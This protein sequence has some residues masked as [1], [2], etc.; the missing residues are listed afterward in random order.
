[1]ELGNVRNLDAVRGIGFIEPE[2]GP[3]LPFNLFELARPAAVRPGHLVMFE[4]SL[5]ERGRMATRV[6]AL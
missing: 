1:L 4:T 3:A 6:K 2:D 5:G